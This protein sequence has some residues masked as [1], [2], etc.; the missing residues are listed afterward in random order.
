MADATYMERRTLGNAGPRW[1]R[2]IFGTSCLGNLYA[3]LS[4]PT[5]L[6]ICREWFRNADAPVFLDT[7]GKYGAGL[8]LETI[9]RNLR[10]LGVAPER[11]VI[12]NKLGWKRAPLDG[13]E[14]TFEPGVWAK[15]EHDAKLCI[16]YDGI[17]ECWREGCELLGAPYS[18]ELV[19]VHDPDEYLQAATSDADRGQRLAN[20]LDAYRALKELQRN[21]EVKAVGVGSKD[22]HVIRQIDSAVSLDWV[23]LA[24][25]LTIFN[26]PPELLQFVSDLA[27]RG[28]VVINSAVF[29]A[30]FLTGGRFFDYRV[31]SPTDDGP[32]FAW[33][34]RF[35]E[36]CRRHDVKPAV[37]CVQFALSPPGIAAVALNSSRPCRV[38]ENIAAIEASVPRSFWADAKDAGLIASGYPYLG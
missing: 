21:G 17:L 27:S 1:P 15:L 30:G 6:D 23:M 26:H 24:N 13:P 31:P 3:A 2:I 19:S 38:S 8:A 4:D 9:G 29:H 36:L 16:G 37:A 20:I 5:K 22:W 7:A 25:S 34:A 14:P 32:L 33:R 28:V 35:Q 18:T 11:V 12:S 10:Q